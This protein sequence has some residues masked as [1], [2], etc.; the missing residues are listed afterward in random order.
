LGRKQARLKNAK[1][2]VFNVLKEFITGRD[3]KALETGLNRLHV[4]TQLVETLKG[5]VDICIDGYN[6]DPRELY[7]IKEVIDWV[8]KLTKMYLAYPIL[9]LQ[10]KAARF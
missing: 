10:M 9:F 6:E 5:K 8:N 3:D 2:L 1:R 4:N 7:E